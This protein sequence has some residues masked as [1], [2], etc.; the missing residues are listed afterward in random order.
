MANELNMLREKIG[1][2]RGAE[3]TIPF[4]LFIALIFALPQIAMSQIAILYI[5]VVYLLVLQFVRLDVLGFCASR[6]K[7]HHNDRV[8]KHAYDGAM[9]DYR[10][11]LLAGAVFIAWLLASFTAKPGETLPLIYKI[12]IPLG[13]MYVVLVLAFFPKAKDP[14]QHLDRIYQ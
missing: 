11:S 8:L 7:C 3:L 12:F 5:T 14:A 4:V 1:L 9:R 6:Q 10:G 13:Y 2:L